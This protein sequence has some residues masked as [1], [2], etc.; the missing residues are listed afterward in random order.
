MEARC[1]KSKKR[2]QQ[3]GREV[4]RGGK[5]SGG[6]WEVKGRCVKTWKEVGET[7]GEDTGRWNHPSH[8]D[9]ISLFMPFIYFIFNLYDLELQLLSLQWEFSLREGKKAMKLHTHTHTL[10]QRQTCMWALGH[11]TPTWSV[12]GITLEQLTW[13]WLESRSCYHPFDP[14]IQLVSKKQ[15]KTKTCLGRKSMAVSLLWDSVCL[16]PFFSGFSPSVVL[17]STPGF[18]LRASSPRSLPNT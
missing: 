4:W 1:E 18:S 15:N 6:T 12:S 7:G 9:A 5:L 14:M 3:G 8:L 2:K 10:L 11:I 17:F 13:L 16:L